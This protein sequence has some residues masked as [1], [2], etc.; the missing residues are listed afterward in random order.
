MGFPALAGRLTFLWS[1]VV[2]AALAA[3]AMLLIW[4]AYTPA[5]PARDVQDRLQGYVKR[6]DMAED[7]EMRRP[8]FERTL[9]APLHG[10]LRALGSLMPKRNVEITRLMLLQ[11]GEPGRLTVLDFFGLRI[12]T[13]ILMGGSY[14]WLA[15]GQE[16]PFSELLRNAIIAGVIGFFLPL[17]WL[18]MKASSRQH[19][20]RRALP[21]A[22]DLL[23]IGVEA[24]LAFESALLRVGER[25]DNPLTRE[26]R[27]AVGEM[28]VGSSRE[29]ALQRMADR[30]GV[31]DLNIFVAVLVQ[32]AQL[33]VSIAQVLHNQAAEM[34]LK[35]SQHAEELAREAGVKMAFP[36]V[37]CIFPSLFAVILGPALP[38]IVS[39]LGNVG[40][41]SQVP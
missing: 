9:Q 40:G 36:L 7:G 30:C 23:T 22:L 12:L 8:F 2:F 35:R 34:R 17:L 24:G 14:L 10:L 26:F 27:R 11:A 21:D 1:P 18:K 31:P 6:E 38:T 4:L 20:I 32:S 19:E 13:A 16:L 15:A 25:W 33:G 41:G 28:R 39:V 3:L 37:F 29:T 5:R